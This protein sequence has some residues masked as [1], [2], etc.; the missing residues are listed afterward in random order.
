MALPCF[1]LCKDQVSLWALTFIRASWSSKPCCLLASQD[2]LI[3]PAS[4]WARLTSCRLG[5]LKCALEGQCHEEPRS[6]RARHLSA[7]T[8]S[9]VLTARQELLGAILGESETG[10]EERKLEEP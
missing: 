9:S 10:I 8:G 3:G 6:T 2:I 4:A 5:T 7:V 1:L